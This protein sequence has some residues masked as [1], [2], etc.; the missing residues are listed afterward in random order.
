MALN[1][2]LVVYDEVIGLIRFAASLSI[3][4]EYVDIEET[5]F[6]KLPFYKKVYVVLIH[7]NLGCG[8]LFLIYEQLIDHE[9]LINVLI[10]CK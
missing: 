5:Y 3:G 1:E 7:L 2:V 9:D 8:T 10:R 4:S 6:K